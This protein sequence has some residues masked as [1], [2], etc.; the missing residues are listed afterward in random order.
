MCTE[1]Y[2]KENPVYHLLPVGGNSVTLNVSNV[3][4]VLNYVTKAKHNEPNLH[5]KV[6]LC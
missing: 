1:I 4:I 6:C 2:F 3:Q 5:A